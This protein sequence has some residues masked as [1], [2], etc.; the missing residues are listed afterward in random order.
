MILYEAPHRVLRTMTDLAAALGADRRASVARELT[1][2]HETVL[3]GTLGDIELGEPRGEYVLVIA[4]ATSVAAVPDD[5]AV[6]AALRVELAAGMS[7]RD[8]A[9]A[10][11]RRLGVARR[12]AYDLAVAEPGTLTPTTLGGAAGPVESRRPRGRDE[13]RPDHPDG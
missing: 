5:D 12:V 1:K 2:L 8:A 6:R 10:V 3:H 4:G 7:R 13:R 11:A 9:A